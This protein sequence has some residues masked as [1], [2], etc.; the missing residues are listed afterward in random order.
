MQQQGPGSSLREFL[1]LVSIN[2]NQRGGRPTALHRTIGAISRRLKRYQQSNPIGKA[3]KNIAHHYDIGNEFYRLFYSC[4]YFENDDDTLEAAQ[5]AKCRLI[6]AKL[7][8]VPG[9]RILDIGSGWGGLAIFCANE[10]RERARR[11]AL[12]GATCTF[13]TTRQSRRCQRPC[14]I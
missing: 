8:L 9:Q 11:Y 4:A 14:S 1:S 2:Q 12:E 10:R 6:A 3:Q 5:R 7:D 13:G